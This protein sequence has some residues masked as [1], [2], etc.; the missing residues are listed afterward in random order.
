MKVSIIK[1]YDSLVNWITVANTS[2]FSLDT[3]LVDTNWLSMEIAGISLCNGDSACYIDLLDNDQQYLMLI[4]INDLLEHKVQKIIYHNAPFDMMVLQK[5]DLN[6]VT[7]LFCTMTAAHLI[8]ET[9]PKSL[10]QLAIKYL[11]INANDV[12]DFETA[13]EN[14]FHTD[15][16]YNYALDDAIWTW[17]LY[18]LFE[19]E[20]STQSLEE[21]FYNIEMPFQF[22]LMDLKINGALIDTNALKSL[23]A[24]A[25]R[26]IDTLEFEMYEAANIEKDSINLNSPQQLVELLFKL[27]VKLTEKTE[28]SKVYP[29]GVYSTA[30]DVLERVKDQHRFVELLLE[31]KKANSLMV[32]FLK[33]LPLFIEEDGRIRA[34]FHNTV[35]VTGRLSST[36]PN[37]QQLPKDNTG[38]LPLRQVIIPAKG[39]KLICA[40]YSGQ[41]LRVLA[42]VSQDPNMIDAFNKK[43]DV[44][45]MI[46]NIF[47]ELNIPAEALITS[48]PDY[49]THKKKFKVERDK[50]KTVNFGLAYGKTAYG[51]SKDW[52]IP[53]QEAQEFID[54]YFAR[55]PLLKRAMDEC[56]EELRKYKKVRTFLGRYRRFKYI[57]NRAIRQAFN[58]LIQSPSADMMKAAAGQF[59]YII[60]EHP[61]WGCLLV[62]SVHDELVYETKE[63][64]ADVV[65]KELIEVMESAVKISLPIEV[66]AGIGDNYAEAK[67]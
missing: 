32:K 55:F 48:H 66:D 24:K 23:R 34:N 30:N 25:Q 9:Q 38:P 8:D 7:D 60:L 4:A 31:Y 65:A 3:E 41:E 67:I 28:P 51:F 5:Y 19:K 40:D 46:A 57:S 47:F 27:G 61:E 49:N 13:S 58:H 59:R 52:N 62:L 33:P 63:E 22:C 20:L 44:H 2:V 11:H 12:I 29:D 64:Y 15:R 56:K 54:S 43:M 35:A 18:E 1:T 16:F 17:Y 42:H 39:R 53:V 10:K 45:L 21:L 37:L 14:G 6:L 26:I 36:K 50:I